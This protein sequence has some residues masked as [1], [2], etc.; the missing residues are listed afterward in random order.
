[1]NTAS[2]T[3]T[4][5]EKVGRLFPDLAAGGHALLDSIAAVGM[6]RHVAEGTVMFDERNPCAGFPLVLDGTIRV[7]QRYPNGREMELY[8][9]QAGESCLLSGSCLLSDADYDATG[10]AITAVELFVLPA[11]DFHRFMANEDAFRRHVF[12]NFGARLA[13]LLQMLQAVTYQKL[14]QRLARLL[15]TSA[16]ANG[17]VSMTHQVLADTLGSVR[18]IVTRL[19]RSFEDRGWVKLGRERITLVDAAALVQLAD[20]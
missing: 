1:M 13:S 18:E 7:V 9:V 17:M 16:D 8:R 12:S 15:T 11:G 3:E 20:A 5:A 2:G 14:D 4:L 10:I 6:Y 19:L